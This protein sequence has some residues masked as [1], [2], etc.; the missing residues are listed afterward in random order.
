[1]QKLILPMNQT[2]VLVGYKNAVYQTEWSRPH[3]GVD[4]ANTTNDK[5]VWAMGEGEVIAAGMDNVYGGT[6]VVLYKDVYIHRTGEIRDLIAR[7]YHMQE[8]YCKKGQK[9]TTASKI[10]LMGN[11]GQYTS[12]PHLHVELDLDTKWP[13]YTIELKN[14][15]NIMKHGTGVD[16]T[17]DPSG[18]LY[19]KASA[20]DNQ[21][22]VP[23]KIYENGNWFAREDWV[24]PL[25]DQPKDYEQLYNQTL[26][27]LEEQQQKYTQLVQKLCDLCKQAQE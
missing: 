18:V 24:L 6:A 25:Y 12:G 14:D 7:C 8:L 13:T 23:N 15:S 26:L 2:Q 9:I 22:L 19:V 20:P 5:T 27:Q 16:T 21:T 10:G 3:Y 4:Y 11:T 1:M 17:I